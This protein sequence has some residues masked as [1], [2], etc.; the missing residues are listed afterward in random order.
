MMAAPNVVEH[1]FLIGEA[2][3]EPAAV[4]TLKELY[5][6]VKSSTIFVALHDFPPLPHLHIISQD[7]PRSKSQKL[8]NLLARFSRKFGDA[9]D[10]KQFSSLLKISNHFI[11]PITRRKI[12]QN[13]VQCGPINNAMA[14]A[15]SKGTS[16]CSL[17]RKMCAKSPSHSP[18]RSTNQTEG[19]KSA[20]PACLQTFSHLQLETAGLHLQGGGDPDP[21]DTES[22]SSHRQTGTHR[23]NDAHLQNDDD[24]DDDE[25]ND[26][27]NFSTREKL[28]KD[29]KWMIVSKDV[30]STGANTLKGR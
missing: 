8:Q 10:K 17:C 1:H 9:F 24:D 13:I 14:M 19:S 3:L 2:F 6:K 28:S 29:Q 23:E 30:D 4:D 12:A 25:D 7:T 16:F 5:D 20:L 18:N 11:K 21:C 15:M 22:F 27:D 26:V